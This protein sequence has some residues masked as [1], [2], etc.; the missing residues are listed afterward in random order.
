MATILMRVLIIGNGGSGKSTLAH[1]LSN[2][3]GLPAF[4]LD[5]YR[6]H[7][8]WKIV[9]D[10]EFA[11]TLKVLIAQEKWIIEGWS[12]HSTM[13]MRLERA[14]LIIYLAYPFWFCLWNALKRHIKYLFRQNPFDPPRSLMIFKT[15]IMLKAMWK[16]YKVYEPDLRRIL[17]EYSGKCIIK[18]KSRQELSE[19]YPLIVSKIGA[20]RSAVI[21]STL[22]QQL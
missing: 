14:D 6:M 5:Q 11:E 22:F 16:V 18:L 20:N 8:G 3:T 15:R 1:Q 2:D 21:D 13:R 7:P 9:P 12:L 19:Y 10:D 4:H 17:P